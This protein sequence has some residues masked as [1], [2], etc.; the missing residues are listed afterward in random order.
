[1]QLCQYASGIGNGCTASLR[2]NVPQLW[3]N[4]QRPYEQ[5]HQGVAKVGVDM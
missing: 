5:F 1:M 4:N 2:P 3:M